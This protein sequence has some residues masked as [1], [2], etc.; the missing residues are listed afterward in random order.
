MDQARSTIDLRTEIGRF[1]YAQQLWA[2]FCQD[3]RDNPSKAKARL[4]SGIQVALRE[5]VNVG[6][7]DK[8][9]SELAMG[10]D[11]NKAELLAALNAAAPEPRV[12]LRDMSRPEG[13]GGHCPLKEHEQ[14][15][16]SYLAGLDVAARR[17]LVIA[18][19][20]SLMRGRDPDARRGI[21]DWI[22][23]AARSVLI[24][25]NS[26]DPRRPRRLPPR[27]QP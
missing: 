5:A 12:P 24:E 20:R 14:D 18:A 15:H 27:G 1:T 6:H 23:R 3:M 26:N 17:L 10:E 16:S 25:T 7:P 19:L 21:V 8:R 13:Y 22:L 4:V 2:R 9:E 11:Q